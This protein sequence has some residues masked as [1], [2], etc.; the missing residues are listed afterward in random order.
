MKLFKPKPRRR[1]RV[2]HRTAHR[3]QPCEICGIFRSEDV[4]DDKVVGKAGDGFDRPC[5]PELKPRY[6]NVVG[7]SRQ[8]SISSLPIC[9]PQHLEVSAIFSVLVRRLVPGAIEIA[10]PLENLE[11]PVRRSRRAHPH[12]PQRVFRVQSPYNCVHLLRGHRHL[13]VCALVVVCR[14]FREKRYNR[15]IVAVNIFSSVLRTRLSSRP[16][17]LRAC[18]RVVNNPPSMRRATAFV[19]ALSLVLTVEAARRQPLMPEPLLQQKSSASNSTETTGCE[20]CCGGGSCDAAFKGTPG[21]CCG[22]VLGKSFCCPSS[23][24]TFGDATCMRTTTDGAFRCHSVTRSNIV[25]RRVSP[26]YSLFSLFIPVAL[27]AACCMACFRK[28]AQQQQ[29]VVPYGQTNP[30]GGQA[31]AYP[32]GQCPPGSAHY[33]NQ[34]TRGYGASN[35]AGAGASIPPQPQHLTLPTSDQRVPSAP[36]FAHATYP[37]GYPTT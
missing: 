12:A 11:F 14:G 19:V 32:P 24:S 7:P 9:P 2:A 21:T 16:I 34:Q 1:H 35:L 23:A 25:R 17:S 31:Y 20:T 27:F 18:A 37:T 22:V 29:V 13:G 6:L 10:Q 30:Y 8:V 28:P 33:Q 15:E 26:W 5:L 3:W 4:S 36:P